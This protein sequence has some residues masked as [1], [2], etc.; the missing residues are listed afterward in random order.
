MTPRCPTPL[1]AQLYG[2]AGNHSIHAGRLR[3]A[4]QALDL[5][6]PLARRSRDDFVLAENRYFRGI[7][8]VQRARVEPARDAFTEVLAIMRR[9]DRQTGISA[10]LDCLA[11]VADLRGDHATAVR[12]R[13]A[14]DDVDRAIGDQERL[15]TGLAR[16]AIGAVN[17][18]DLDEARAAVAEAQRSPSRRE[19]VAHRMGQ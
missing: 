14:A 15:A 11:D 13:D 18:G 3:D 10:A 9:M 12:H 2:H 17:A 19:L 16:R 1:R 8:D 6:L 7:V 5:G 4:E